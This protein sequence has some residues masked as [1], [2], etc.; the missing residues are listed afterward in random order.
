MGNNFARPTRV[1]LKVSMT[2]EGTI[3]HIL[4]TW[5]EEENFLLI[6]PGLFRRPI[7]VK[8]EDTFNDQV[9]QMLNLFTWHQARK[10]HL[11][12]QSRLFRSVLI[13]L[14]MGL[15]IYWIYEFVEWYI[16]LL[17]HMS[18]SR[19]LVNVLLSV[20]LIFLIHSFSGFLCF[21]FFFY[22]WKLAKNRM[23]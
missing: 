17:E 20:I 7:S 9:L 4:F 18:W 16:I 1:E 13:M 10:G 5:D 2:P 12:I 21:L 11:L 15:L 22:F 23:N 6:Q 14:M 19:F 3:L 8:L